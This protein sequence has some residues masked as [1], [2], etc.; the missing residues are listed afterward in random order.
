MSS[1]RAFD[2]NLARGEA[3]L[4]T[5]VLLSLVLV[6]SVQAALWN[7]KEVGVLWASDALQSLSWGD[8]FLEKATLWVA[9]FGASLATYHGKHIGI[10]VL[11]R[12]AAPK[13]RA[14]MRGVSSLF[15]GVTCLFFARVV[16]SALLAKSV[17]IPADYGVFGAD[18]E[19]V[20]ICLGTAEAIAD[21]GYTR[22][23]L[24]CAL[25]SL[26]EGLGMTV[27]TPERAMDLLVP[28]LFMIIGVRFVAYGIGAFARIPSGGIPDDELEGGAEPPGALSEGE[29]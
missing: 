18:F 17:R 20:H 23:D 14:F 29:G 11:A 12:I 2:R 22:P 7:L 21:A 10:D 4:A 25:R 6:A 19:T 15:A 24:F 5:L 3:A 16:L 8:A 26:L 27:N 1:L 28:A 9:M 13:Q